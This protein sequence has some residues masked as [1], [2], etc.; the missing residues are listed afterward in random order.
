[1]NKCKM[2]KEIRVFD[3]CQWD[4]KAEYK[5]RTGPGVSRH[6]LPNKQEGLGHKGGDN[7]EQNWSKPDNFHFRSAKD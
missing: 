4:S 6:S 1:M 7:N 5:A 3:C 2:E